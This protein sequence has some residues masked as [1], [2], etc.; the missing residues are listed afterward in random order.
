ME[1]ISTLTIDDMKTLDTVNPEYMPEVIDGIGFGEATI[2][3]GM[4]MLLI[5]K[6]LMEASDEDMVIY[7]DWLE[8]G[9]LSDLI[10]EGVTTLKGDV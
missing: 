6:V 10:K 4:C 3:F 5:S 7:K 9:Y 8:M 1:L 2:E